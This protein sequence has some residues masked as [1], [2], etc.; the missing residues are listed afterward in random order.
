MGK[1]EQA[2]IHRAGKQLK[3][4]VIMFSE[5]E[6]LGKAGKVTEILEEIKREE[7]R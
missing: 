5:G 4:G 6:I 2:L 3:L 1:M 7:S